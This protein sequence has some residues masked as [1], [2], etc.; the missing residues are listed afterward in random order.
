MSTEAAPAGTREEQG[1]PK[2]L[3]WPVTYMEH[4]AD[5]CSTPGGRSDLATGQSLRDLD[6]PWR[7]LPHLLSRIPAHYP[8][9][10]LAY[11]AVAGMYAAQAPNPTL[12]RQRPVIYDPA[13]GNFGW[14]LAR[15]ADRGVL[16]EDGTTE[17]LQH[18]ARQRSLRSLLRNLQPV[19]RR[20]GD[21]NVPLSWPHLLRDLTRWPRYRTDV[22]SRW[23]DSRYARTPNPTHIEEPA[24]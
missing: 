13:V 16:R 1:P 19:I 7:M 23:M 24:A 4:V 15:A 22:A 21:E 8:D 3:A 14:S 11:L 6:E 12:A 18:L 10:K 2:W 20:L 17:L 5:V 9:I